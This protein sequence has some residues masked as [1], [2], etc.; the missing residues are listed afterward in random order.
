MINSKLYHYSWLILLMLALPGTSHAGKKAERYYLSLGTSLAVGI[1]PD[2]TGENQRTDEGYPDQLFSM[3]KPVA[4]RLQLVKLGCPG[5][6]TQT[7]VTGGLPG[8]DYEFGS[9][10]NDAVNF[11]QTHGRKVRFVTIDLGVND[12]LQSG[13]INIPVIDEACLFKAI[14]ETASRLVAIMAT[15]KAVAHPR[16][17]FIGMNY[18]N[19][20]LALWINPDL[21]PGVGPAIAKQ[22]A[23]LAAGFNGALEQ[24]YGAFGIPTADVARAYQSDRFDFQVPL[25]PLGEVPLNVALICQLTYMCVPGP[26]GPNIHATPD[27]YR[28]VAFAFLFELFKLRHS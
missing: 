15:L 2:A 21:P 6:T 5:E 22:S 10:L 18:Y 13:C 16:T 3:I 24:V 8:C 9:Q 25:P 19:T 12:L 27:G 23:E 4:K 20:C 28:V 14:D 7:M 1:Q 11:L 26:V 17:K